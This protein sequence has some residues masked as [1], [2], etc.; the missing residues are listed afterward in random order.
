VLTYWLFAISFFYLII[1]S[2][3]WIPEA[4]L[5][6]LENSYSHI[7]SMDKFVD[8]L[9][10]NEEVHLLILG[11]GNS[12][13]VRLSN[14][15]QLHNSSLYRLTEGIRLHNA[16]PNSKLVFT[17]SSGGQKKSPAN[18]SAKAAIEQGVNTKDII[19]IS[20][21]WNTYN[22]ALAY[23]KHFGVEHKLFLI[24]DAVHMPRAM[25]LFKKVGLDPI[26]CP[27]YFRLRQNNTHRDFTDYFPSSHY[28]TYSEIV[29]QAYLGVLWAKIRGIV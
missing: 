25:M 10:D 22:E 23:L 18:I 19:V 8:S 28:I 5:A 11:A 27:T 2:T 16:I 3:P 7:K 24:T 9:V 12:N 15:T 26:P 20:E 14:T 4:L 13:D 1:I 29:L 17:G 6:Q 21:G